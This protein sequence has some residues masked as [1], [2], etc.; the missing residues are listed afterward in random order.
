MPESVPSRDEIVAL[1]VRAHLG[2][3]P[4]STAAAAE[5]LSSA[6]KL[7]K[8]VAE[9]LGAGLGQ[10]DFFPEIEEIVDFALGY[11]PPANEEELWTLARTWSA[12]DAASRKTILNLVGRDI[13]HHELQRIAIPKL[14]EIIDEKRP[15]RERELRVSLGFEVPMPRV[16]PAARAERPAAS[17]GS[18]ASKEAAPPRAIPTRMPMPEKR[19]PKAAA[20][21]EV[22][23]FHHPK[24]GEGVLEAHDGI[25]PDAKLTIKFAAG[26]K[27]LLAK[28]VTE[29]PG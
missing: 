16:K 28:Y 23:R 27:T 10:W 24:F 18:G 29:I 11:V 5:A 22:K 8:R 4:G 6:S 12:D 26:A 2:S 3:A 15:M 19:A 21:V 25:G 9:N 13:L 1:V 20:V 7:P 14:R 17:K